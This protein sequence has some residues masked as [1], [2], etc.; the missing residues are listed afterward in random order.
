[1]NKIQEIQDLG[2][3]VWLDNIHRKMLEKGGLQNL[4]DKGV[5]GVTSNPSIFEKAIAGSSDYDDQ[6]VALLDQE[7]SII[8][9]YEALVLRDIGMAADTLKEVYDRTNGA[10]GYVSLEVSP[11]LADDTDGTVDEAK[12][13]FTLLNR[14]NIMIKVPATEA[15]IPAIE[16]LIATG[17]NVNVTLIFALTNYEDIA[18]A[19]IKGLEHAANA[20]IALQEIASVASFFVSRVDTAVDTLLDEI[21]NKE[22]QGKLA[23]ANAKLA[24]RRFKQIFNGSAWDHLEQM[25]ARVQRPL[26]ASTSTKNPAY[27]DTL[28]VDELIGPSTVNTVPP[29]TL[30][31]YLEHGKVEL[32]LEEDIGAAEDQFNQ[33]RDLGIDFNAVTQK[34][35]E[36][37][38]K[39]FAKSYR[40]LIAAINDKCERM[41]VQPA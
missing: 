20:G 5:S 19:Y 33:I 41:R 32:T 40:N 36:D 2:Q 4:I 7:A 35:Q 1:M 14:P 23:I 3:S 22:L 15:G 34:L 30:D 37:G 24:Y 11:E 13:Y 10:D 38:V 28:Y 31:S 21:G 9:I 27:P 29:T 8:E 16:A 39:A 12:R 6:L 26:W 18:Q 17:V 25:G